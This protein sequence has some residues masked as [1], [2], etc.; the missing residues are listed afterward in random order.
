MTYGAN[1]FWPFEV[2]GTKFERVIKFDSG[3]SLTLD[4]VV[5]CKIGGFD[6]IISFNFKV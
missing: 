5:T 2:P 3:Q 4:G 6:G 1:S